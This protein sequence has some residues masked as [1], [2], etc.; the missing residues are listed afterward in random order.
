MFDTLIVFVLPMAFTLLI[1]CALT[2][3]VSGLMLLL[4]N[5][6]RTNLALRHPYLDQHPWERFPISIR[7][8]ILLDYFL[9]LAFPKRRFWIIDDA[10]RRLAH[11]SPAD[12]PTSIKWPLIGFWGGCFVGLICLLVVWT[13]LLL[14]MNF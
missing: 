6:R 13:L 11:V 3:I 4:F 1:A 10:N 5:L 9:R 8:A 14:K 2:S 7:M 12:V